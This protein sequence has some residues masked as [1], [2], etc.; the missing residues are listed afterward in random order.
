MSAG[1]V[2]GQHLDVRVTAGV[3]EAR[4]FYNN[5]PDAPGQDGF[6][7]RDYVRRATTSALLNWHAPG[8]ASVTGG[9]EYEDQRQRGVAGSQASHHRLRPFEDNVVREQVDPLDA[10]R[11]T[12]S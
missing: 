12:G 7:S 11:H 10:S 6:W 2:L 4:L 8:G 3:K 1:R 9:I 5:E